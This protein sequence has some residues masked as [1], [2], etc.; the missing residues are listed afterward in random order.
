MRIRSADGDLGPEAVQ[1]LRAGALD[2][3]RI[4]LLRAEGPLPPVSQCFQRASDP[5]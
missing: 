1:L 3:G 2:F 4:H 5:E